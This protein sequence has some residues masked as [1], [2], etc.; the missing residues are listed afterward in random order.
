MVGV[1]V[2]AVD[3]GEVTYVIRTTDPLHKKDAPSA[4][5]YYESDRQLA[6]VAERGGVQLSDN[7]PLDLAPAVHEFHTRLSTKGWKEGRWYLAIFAHNTK[8]KQGGYKIVR[9]L[10]A[11]DVQKD[12]VKLINMES[13][14]LTQFVKCELDPPVVKAGEPTVVRI[15]ANQDDLQGVKIS[16]PH[17]LAK[18]DILP[19]FVYDEKTTTAMLDDGTPD[20][21]KG[22]LRNNGPRDHRRGCQKD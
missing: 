7:G 20:G 5:P 2:K 6:F 4:L 18:E 9:A 11:V 14:S 8:K 19:D 17:H 21:I 12:Q 3:T 16:V 22:L 13:A 15:E 1:K 10:F